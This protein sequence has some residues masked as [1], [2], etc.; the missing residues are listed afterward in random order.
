MVAVG[1]RSGRRKEEVRETKRDKLPLTFP[2]K[3][4]VSWPYLTAE[5][6]GNGL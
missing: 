5:T 4:L 2:G 6:L 1:R 3:V